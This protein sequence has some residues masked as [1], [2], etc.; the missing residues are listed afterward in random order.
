MGEVFTALVNSK[1]NQ[2]PKNIRN[3][4]LTLPSIILFGILQV[5]FLVLNFIY[6]LIFWVLLI[7]FYKSKFY[8]YKKVMVEKEEIE[9]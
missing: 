3:L 4:I 2:I 6:S 5:I 9:L 7:V 8:H 1:I